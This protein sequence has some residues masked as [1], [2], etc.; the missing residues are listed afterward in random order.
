[1]SKAGRGANRSGRPRSPRRVRAGTSIVNDCGPVSS[2]RPKGWSL[3]RT[4]GDSERQGFIGLSRSR[5][6]FQL[7]H[8]STNCGR[9]ANRLHV[10]RAR[11]TPDGEVLVSVENGFG[12]R[13]KSVA[14]VVTKWWVSKGFRTISAP[15]LGTLEYVIP[16][17]N[18]AELLWTRDVTVKNIS[19]GG[20]VV[21][22]RAPCTET[23]DLEI[24]AA[25]YAAFVWWRL[26]RG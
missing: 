20:A 11:V 17:A 16:D 2:L 21:P 26:G 5:A 9:P 6:A 4:Q 10:S 22:I 15:A 13:V 3:H 7:L 25:I 19:D 23:V 8:L 18:D 14:I 12:G 24:R 1:M